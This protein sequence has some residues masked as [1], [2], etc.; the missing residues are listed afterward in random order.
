MCWTRT[1]HLIS[2]ISNSVLGYICLCLLGPSEAAAVVLALG[3]TAADAASSL[4]FK[5]Q[6]ID[7]S[8]AAALLSVA[9]Y[10]S[11]DTRARAVP[12]AED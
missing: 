11:I 1:R 12:D 7:R 3:F 6:M 10:L 2:T 9:G 5:G 8:A 4:L